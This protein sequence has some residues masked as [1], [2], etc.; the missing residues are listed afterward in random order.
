MKHGS[1][2]QDVAAQAR[3]VILRDVLAL[4][5]PLLLVLS[6]VATAAGIAAW[7]ENP[8]RIVSGLIALTITAASWVL[9]RRGRGELAARL[10]IAGLAAIA[11]YAMFFN[12]GLRAP[13][14]VLLLVVV[15]LSGWIEGRRFATVMALGAGALAVAVAV[16]S[17]AGV[18]ATVDPPAPIVH[19]AFLSIYVALTWI[20]T[21]FP[22][23]RLRQALIDVAAREEALR[24]EQARRQ[25]SE[26]AFKR[27][28][29]QAA[30]LMVLLDA[31]GAVVGI[32]R[33]GL[34]LLGAASA[35]QVVGRTLDGP[36]VWPGGLPEELRR[37]IERTLEHAEPA[38]LETGGQAARNLELDLTPLSDD[39]GVLRSVI[40]EARDV[41]AAVAQQERAARARRLE[42]MGQ[43]AAGVAHDFNNVLSVVLSTSEVMKRDLQSPRGVTSGDVEEGLDIIHGVALRAADLTRRLVTFARKPVLELRAVKLHELLEASQKMLVATLPANVKVELRLGATAHHVR[44]DPGSLESALLNLAVNARDA[45]LPAGG[46]ITISTSTPSPHLVR[47]SVRDTGPG[48]SAEVKAHLFEPFH[49]TKPEGRGNGL[50][51]ASVAGT[52]ES[53]GGAIAVESS[54]SGTVFHLDFPLDEDRS[55]EVVDVVHE[56]DLSGLNALVVDDEVALQRLTP[57]LLGHLHLT[58]QVAPD[59]ERALETFAA[60]PAA[61]DLAVIDL[62]LPGLQGDELARRLLAQ[63][64]A[65]KVVLVSGHALNV[66]LSTFPPDRVR[67]V[68]KPCTAEVLRTAISELFPERP[69]VEVRRQ[70][71]VTTPASSR[72]S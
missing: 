62:V 33:A 30:H 56:A 40:V 34:D 53:H 44:A 24:L 32:N 65:L 12:G 17:R 2:S 1:A 59:A 38:R 46:V 49:T 66:D 68:H 60:A 58:A 45:M 57:R 67:V 43:L 29:E 26:L 19:A 7:H 27:V 70:P 11:S 63:R 20:A 35:E 48:L 25:E 18:V 23:D 21:A 22:Q 50:G 13:A 55:G 64:P 31:R 10:L 39:A 47:V 14:A 3:T 52:V 15:S 51:L 61:F 54:T 72:A 5:L 6:V 8:R 71:R 42:L 36:G 4:A 37:A 9:W 41:S 69:R 28:F 16:L